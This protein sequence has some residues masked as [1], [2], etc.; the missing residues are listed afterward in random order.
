MMAE[1]DMAKM[2]IANLVTRETMSVH[3][4]DELLEEANSRHLKEIEVRKETFAENA[5]SLVH[6]VKGAQ[7]ESV[8]M[9]VEKNLILAHFEEH[10]FG[11]YS[12]FNSNVERKVTWKDA[13]T[14]VKK[15]LDKC[16]NINKLAYSVK[17]A[18]LTRELQQRTG[19]IK[20]KDL[21]LQTML[22]SVKEASRL[23]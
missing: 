9:F 4:N 19:L 10:V 21:E 8:N 11:L 17:L 12:L 22:S 20:S 6:G 7:A 23:R 14:G 18:K 13:M 16:R 5:D 3:R 2:R 15:L 1:L